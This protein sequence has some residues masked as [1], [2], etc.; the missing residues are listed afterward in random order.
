MAAIFQGLSP[1]SDTDDALEITDDLPEGGPVPDAP[2][3]PEEFAPGLTPELKDLME[4]TAAMAEG[5]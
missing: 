1:L 2:E 4:Q 5:N 3:R